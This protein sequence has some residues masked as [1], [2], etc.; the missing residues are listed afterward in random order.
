MVLHRHQFTSNPSDGN[1]E[2][3]RRGFEA[4]PGR[5]CGGCSNQKRSAARCQSLPWPS[6]KTSTSLRETQIEF[7]TRRKML[8]REGKPF[9]EEECE[10][11]ACEILSQRL[12]TISGEMQSVPGGRL[13]VCLAVSQG[14]SPHMARL[15]S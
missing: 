13:D 10:R 14:L 1:R 6:S 15:Y 4:R 3:V 9:D 12:Q 8:K 2:A 5:S 7:G 11:Y